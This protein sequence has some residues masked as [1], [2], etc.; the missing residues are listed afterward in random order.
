MMVMVLMMVM[1]IMFYDGMMLM[2]NSV[3]DIDDGVDYGVNDD[4]VM[5]L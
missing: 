2:V 3:N 5:F 4:G 1:V